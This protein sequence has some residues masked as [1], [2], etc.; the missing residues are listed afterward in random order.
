MQA[1]PAAANAVMRAVL[2]STG[3]TL[4]KWPREQLDRYGAWFL[5]A[6]FYAILVRVEHD[7][8]RR[9]SGLPGGTLPACCPPQVWEEVWDLPHTAA[10]S[11]WLLLLITAGAVVCSW[12]FERRMWC[13][14]GE[15]TAGGRVGRQRRQRAPLLLLL[16]PALMSGRARHLNC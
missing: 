5:F 2:C 14:C 8:G 11:S 16:R 15:A 4:L 3:G 1:L 12:F 10:L 6:L 9:H 7:Q 13:R